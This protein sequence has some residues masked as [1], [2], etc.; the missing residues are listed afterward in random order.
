MQAGEDGV[1]EARFG[2]SWMWE[3]RKGGGF[4]VEGVGF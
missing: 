4:G 3:S 2:G 1:R